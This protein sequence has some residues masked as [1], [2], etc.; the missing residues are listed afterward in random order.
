M[1]G[2]VPLILAHVAGIPLEEAVLS[3]V[4]VLAVGGWAYLRAWAGR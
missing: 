4:P 1:T 3:I 2:A